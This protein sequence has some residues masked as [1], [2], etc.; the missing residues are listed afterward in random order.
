MVTLYG[1]WKIHVLAVWPESCD[2][3]KKRWEKATKSESNEG[4]YFSLELNRITLFL[5][6]ERVNGFI[7]WLR[8]HKSYWTIKWWS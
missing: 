8:Q 3:R 4:R 1:P 2:L 5:K 6:K 7:S